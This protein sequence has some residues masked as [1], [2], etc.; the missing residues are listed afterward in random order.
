[1]TAEEIKSILDN[2][3]KIVDG[4]VIFG[5]AISSKLLAS[6]M[7]KNGQQ[8]T[9]TDEEIEKWAKEYTHEL[10]NGKLHTQG[11][12]LSIFRGA[13]KAFKWIRDKYENTKQS[14]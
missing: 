9:I 3:L 1:M 2:H 8:P 4:N 13:K 5:K 14:Q 11:T 12:Y 6:L 10:V 7:V